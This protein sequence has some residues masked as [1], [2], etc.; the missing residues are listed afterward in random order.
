MKF[1][2]IALVICSMAVSSAHASCTRAGNFVTCTDGSSY[3]QL[4]NTTFGSNSNTGS[5]WSQTQ[6]GNTTF[7]TDSRGNSWS[8]IGSGASRVCN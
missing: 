7:G 2:P 1:V 3:T 6:I 4:G 8:C 5:T